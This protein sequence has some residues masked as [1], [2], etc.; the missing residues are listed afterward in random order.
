MTLDTWKD[1][2]WTYSRQYG[3]TKLRWVVSGGATGRESI[4]NGLKELA[5][6]CEPDS[7]VMVH[8]G[9]RPLVSNDIIADSLSVFRKHGSAVAAIP[10]VEAVFKSSDGC[11][12]NISIPR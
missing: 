5:K 3:I 8:D 7:I 4:E 1:F 12:S 6:V 9:N 10:C 11:T 2:V